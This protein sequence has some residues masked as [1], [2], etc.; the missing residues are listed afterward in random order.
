MAPVPQV[1]HF[2][3]V[4][5]GL[6]VGRPPVLQ[7][8]CGNHVLQVEPVAK[9]EELLSGH[10]LDLV[11]GVPAFD[12]LTQ[13]PSLDRLG[14]D[15]RGYSPGLDR[16]PVGRVD[17][18]VIVAPAGQ[19]RE[20]VVGEVFDHRP[21]A[22]VGTEEVLSDVVAVLDCVA[23]ELAVDG[24]VHL[25]EQ[26]PV[27]VA[28]EQFI[29]AAAPD[30]LDDVPPRTSEDRFQL[31]DDLAVAAHRSVEALQVAVDHPRE[32]VEVFAR[33]ERDGSECL[34]FIHLAVTHE[35]PDP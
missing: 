34:G 31:L 6:Q 21:Q 23:L 28:L 30:D 4:L 7:V 25:V 35:A 5:G 32:V 27:G 3:R 16:G 9:R 10:L 13:C 14:K 26:H 19:F 33:C 1:V 22:G 18:A 8:L 12:S 15:D 17:L 11:G 2:G 20:V 24:G 29:P